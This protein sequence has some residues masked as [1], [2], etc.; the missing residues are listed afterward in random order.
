[1]MKIPTYYPLALH[2]KYVLASMGIHNFIIRNCPDDEEFQE[3][4]RDDENYDNNYIPDIDPRYAQME[5]A[6]DILF[7]LHANDSNMREVRDEI[8]TNIKWDRRRR[9][10][11]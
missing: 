8:M 9:G 4:L 1:M 11:S 6:E 10:R 7:P 2:K 5:A 3:A